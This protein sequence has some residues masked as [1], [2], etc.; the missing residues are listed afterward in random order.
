M[1]VEPKTAA[2]LLVGS[3]GLIYPPEVGSPTS[4]S[5]DGDCCATKEKKLD[6]P[7][8]KPPRCAAA[9]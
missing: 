2:G 3:S 5:P 7:M 8:N 6:S 9:W 4:S 1:S